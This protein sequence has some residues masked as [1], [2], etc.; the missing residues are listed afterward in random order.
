MNSNIHQTFLMLAS[1]ASLMAGAAEKEDVFI[2]TMRMANPHPAN[3]VDVEP[4]KVYLEIRGLPEPD[5][6]QNSTHR[7][8][9]ARTGLWNTHGLRSSP[10]VKWTFNTDGAVKSSPVAVDGLV[11]FGS[12]DRHVYAV[13]A[14]TG[15]MKWKVDTGGPVDCAP[16]LAAGVVYIGSGD[17]LLHA[18]DARTGES[19]WK[20]MRGNQPVLDTPVIGYD[21]VFAYVPG[22]G[23]GLMALD[24]RTG[25]IRCRYHKGRGWKSDGQ[26]HNLALS[27]GIL[28]HVGPV[29]VRSGDPLLFDIQVGQAC[30]ITG[31]FAVDGDIVYV[32]QHN[33]LVA[34][35]LQQ[36]GKKWHALVEDWKSAGGELP[37]R[38][39]HR[40]QAAT[41]CHAGQVYLASMDGSLYAFSATN[42]KRLW[43]FDTQGPIAASPGLTP[44]NT[45]YI[46]SRDKHLYSVDTRDGRLLWTFAAQGCIDTSPCIANGVVYIGSDDGSVYALEAK[47]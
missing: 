35:D 12:H 3:G 41:A 13:D 19:I 26:P 15:V 46:P 11:F 39:K 33:L 45:I 6:L 30:A 42:G 44:D 36:G 37:A 27:N 9:Q 2:G 23:A 43:Q 25:K 17:K 28:L 1:A 34:V 8:N 16:A 47:D 32:G 22:W 14:A 18:I 38:I 31:G 29:D 5:P 20:S 10:R 4:E 40:V 21:A 7:G 24:P